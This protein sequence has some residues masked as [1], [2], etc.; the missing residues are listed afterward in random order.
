[1]ARLRGFGFAL[2]FPNQS[3]RK[4]ENVLDISKIID[5]LESSHFCNGVLKL[6][7]F[8]SKNFADKLFIGWVEA[9]KVCEVFGIWTF[10]GAD[11]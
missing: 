4:F 7:V 8:Q 3:L 2:V 1:M 10:P 11:F 6:E 5:P 9:L